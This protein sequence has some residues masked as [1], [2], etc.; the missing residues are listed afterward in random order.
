MHPLISCCSSTLSTSRDAAPATSGSEYQMSLRMSSR[1]S[2]E[3]SLLRAS[4]AARQ[5]RS[6]RLAGRSPC[7][8]ESESAVRRAATV[9]GSRRACE[10]V[11][12]KAIMR[13]RS[14]AVTGGWMK[15]IV[16]AGTESPGASNARQAPGAVPAAGA[17][18]TKR[19]RSS[20]GAAR[21]FI[22]DCSGANDDQE[23]GVRPELVRL[24]DA[25]PAG[26]LA[27]LGGE[28]SGERRILAR[29]DRVIAGRE[30][31]DAVLQA[32]DLRELGRIEV[33]RRRDGTR[34]EEEEAL[35]AF[36]DENA[37]LHQL[38]LGADDVV[39][40]VL[41]GRELRDGVGERRLLA[42]QPDVLLRHG[43]DP[44]GE[45]GDL[46]VLLGDRRFVLRLLVLD[47]LTKITDRG[48]V[49]RDLR[50]EGRVVSGEAIGPRAKRRDARLAR[51]EPR[52]ERV[53]ALDDG[54]AL[55]LH[56]RDVGLGQRLGTELI[57]ALA[58][59]ELRNLGVDVVHELRRRHHLGQQIILDRNEGI[60]TER[61]GVGERAKLILAFVA[62]G[63]N[64][65]ARNQ[66]AE[67]AHSELG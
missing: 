34:A 45:R 58:R 55:F 33:E 37:A 15:P 46:R 60:G 19:R 31:D 6:C 2:A 32:V 8:I 49:L 28:R 21:H 5:R 43:V 44:G 66:D 3:M 54:G 20:T 13:G 63:E 47:R 38:V 61:I 30:V 12:S 27:I 65:E 42:G 9:S 24:F 22:G 48:L 17:E 35:V 1:R 51:V 4:S 10:G 50:D 18:T 57:G 29:E 62:R 7:E 64:D 25:K 59:L 52:D 26:D 16:S 53:D 67:Q 11:R 14:E 39:R 41:L 40:G 36:F 56:R 23:S